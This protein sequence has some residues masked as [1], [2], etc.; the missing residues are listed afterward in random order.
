[1]PTASLLRNKTPPSNKSPR[2]DT[3]LS[4]GETP[5]LGLWAI[6]NTSS[7]ILLPGQI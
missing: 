7:F 1:M 5:V 6:W 3:K 4:K 2:Y